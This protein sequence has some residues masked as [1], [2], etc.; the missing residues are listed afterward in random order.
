MLILNS[1]RL[2]HL[3]EL[4]P[5]DS[6]N[7]RYGFHTIIGVVERLA[8][9]SVS[10][11]RN[12]SLL[13][14]TVWNARGGNTVIEW[15]MPRAMSASLKELTAQLERF[16][17]KDAATCQLRRASTPAPSD[18]LPPLSDP[19][20]SDPK[21]APAYERFSNAL[22]DSQKGVMQALRRGKMFPMKKSPRRN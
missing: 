7:I 18:P 4:L 10:A 21:P 14:S 17:A 16:K 13:L 20:S 15:E 8:D 1:Q 22:A 3:T 11:L 12:D 9:I 6:A 5:P 19:A 2:I